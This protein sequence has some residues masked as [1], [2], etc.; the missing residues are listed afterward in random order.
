M[1]KKEWEEEYK[2]SMSEKGFETYITK[3]N[4]NFTTKFTYEDYKRMF[5]GYKRIL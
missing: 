5:K 3:H 1:I 2:N 4:P